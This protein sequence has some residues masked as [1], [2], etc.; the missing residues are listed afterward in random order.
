MHELL[1]YVSL[2]LFIEN[3]RKEVVS[4]YGFENPSPSSLTD[5]KLFHSAIKDDLSFLDNHSPYYKNN[6]LYSNLQSVLREKR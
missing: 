1:G 4:D 3:F 6:Q 5:L 2:T